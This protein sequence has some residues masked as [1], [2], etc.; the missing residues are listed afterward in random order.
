MFKPGQLVT[1]QHR[2]GRIVDAWDG[3]A[4]VAFVDDDGFISVRE[5]SNRVLY[6]LR[7][8]RQMRSIWP[9]KGSKECRG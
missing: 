5:L 1:Y 8:S 4:E 9:V 2:V 6:S 7:S 3:F